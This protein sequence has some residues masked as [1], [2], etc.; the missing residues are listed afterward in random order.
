LALIYQFLA[1]PKK[2]KNFKEETL[3]SK[4]FR[5]AAPRPPTVHRQATAKSFLAMGAQNPKCSPL[6]ADVWVWFKNW[7]PNLLNDNFVTHSFLHNGTDVSFVPK[8]FSHLF[9]IR[10]IL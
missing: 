5:R 10:I 2:V 6:L 1:N 3:I 8:F 9:L 7:L 4:N